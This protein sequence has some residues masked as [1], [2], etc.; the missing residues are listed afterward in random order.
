M[1]GWVVGVVPVYEDLEVEDEVVAGGVGGGGTVDKGV[2]G[3]I[4]G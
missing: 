3:S 4:W 1:A 2:V